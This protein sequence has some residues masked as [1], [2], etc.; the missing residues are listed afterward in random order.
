M[1]GNDIS[2]LIV[3]AIIDL[4]FIAMGIVL[5]CGKG[6]FLIA[7]YNTMTKEEKDKYNSVELSKFMGKIIIVIALII[8]CFA[9]GGIYNILWLPVV[10]LIAILGLVIFACVYA[11]T[12][13][14]F[15]K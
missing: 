8:P 12:K 2:G 15:K 11:N 13:N 9:L 7:G 6:A 3:M 4:I 10:G 1:S 5:L 14:R